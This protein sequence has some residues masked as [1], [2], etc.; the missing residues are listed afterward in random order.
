MNWRR[1]IDYHGSR[2]YP[3]ADND[4]RPGSRLWLDLAVVAGWAKD[5]LGR[6][7]NVIAPRSEDFLP[8]VLRREEQFQLAAA[9]RPKHDSTGTAEDKS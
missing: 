4:E 6:M 5:R 3:A 2:T 8:I 1:Q 7:W 9:E